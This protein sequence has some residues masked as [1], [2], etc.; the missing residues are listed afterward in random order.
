[1]DLDSVLSSVFNGLAH[2]T[3]E[4]DK[5]LHVN[6][7]EFKNS[8]VDN[9]IHELEYF[10]YNSRDTYRLKQMPKNTIYE[11]D[12]DT[13]DY[14]TTIVDSNIT[15]LPRLDGIGDNIFYI[16]KNLCDLN[17][18]ESLYKTEDIIQEETHYKNYLQLQDGV[19]KVVDKLGNILQ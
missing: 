14:F 4:L 3:T 13:E 6:K 7:P 5:N 12:S 11:I 17:V 19:Y 1:M 10:L 2:V 8:F 18:D 15:N 16:P 9:F